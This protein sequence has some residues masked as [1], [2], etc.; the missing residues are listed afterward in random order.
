MDL[1]HRQYLAH[2]IDLAARGR[3]AGVR[4]LPRWAN[5]AFGPTGWLRSL[6]A[7]AVREGGVLVEGFL[8]LFGDE[9]SDAAAA[10]LRSFATGG[11][12]IRVDEANAIWD[13]QLA[14]LRERLVKIDEAA[15]RLTSADPD[16]ARLLKTLDA[17]RRQTKRLLGAIG[18]SP[19]HSTLVEYG[20]L[21]N[22]A[23]TDARTTLE[24][25]LTWEEKDAEGHVTYHNDPREYAR[26][27]SQALTE[28]APGNTY[29]V[30][31]YGHEVSGLDI[32]VK[33]RA[34]RTWRVC[35]SCGY[36]R[37]A[38]AAADITPCDRC[39]EG[40]IA[41]S[42]QL[43]DVLVPTRVTS[44]DRR[45]DARIGDD[46][47]D[48]SRSPTPRPPSSTWVRQWPGHGDTPPRR[49][50]STTPDTQRSGDSTLV[51]CASTAVP[52][53][54]SQGTPYESTTSTPACRVAAP[55]MTVRRRP[56]P[57]SASRRRSAGHAAP[58]TTD[59]G[60]RAGAAP[61][62]TIAHWCSPTN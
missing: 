45:D 32:G 1:L 15:A 53:I 30:R 12:P 39:G 8:A 16:D 28:I 24:A 50:V 35:P 49:S 54:R 59:R 43:Y 19:A 44:R 14:D 51:G 47:D 46:D 37:T 29:Y 60:A 55:L 3:F 34:V 42:G 20:L 7:A 31:G 38:L 25:T 2:L 23:L 57:G 41:D 40:N 21:P 26:P 5:A 56:R 11:L 17:D 52:T 22:Y 36:V 61:R 33:G 58:N 10:D 6:A 48:R 9:I 4:G 62:W 27:A 13:E 18:R